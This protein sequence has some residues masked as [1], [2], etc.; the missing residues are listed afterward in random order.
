MT[1]ATRGGLRLAAPGLLALAAAACGGA[2]AS[3]PISVAVDEAAFAATDWETASDREEFSVFHS[4]EILSIPAGQIP[5]F[6]TLDRI[7]GATVELLVPRPDGL[8]PFE[9]VDSVQSGE[10]GR[11]ASLPFEH[12][13]HRGL[14]QG[15]YS[16]PL[17]LSTGD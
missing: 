14:Q 2:P 16:T 17:F 5:D 9:V 15:T 8:P 4:G 7:E 3:G 6:A 11:S 12:I 10:G 1:T 13:S